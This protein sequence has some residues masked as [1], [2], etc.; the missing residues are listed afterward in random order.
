M[1]LFP[2]LRETNIGEFLKAHPETIKKA[3]KTSHFEYEPYLE[4]IEHDGSVQ[5]R[6]INPD[7]MVRRD[8]GFYDIYDLKTALL[9]KK[10]IVKGERKRRRFIDCVEEGV[11]QLSNYREY[12]QYPKNQE[13][14]KSKYG[15]EVNEPKLVLLVGS[16][17]NTDKRQIVEACRRY[18]NANIID[19]DTFAHLFYGTVAKT[20]NVET[21]RSN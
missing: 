8:D 2:G 21:R 19:F 12:F 6:A 10:N 9:T 18:K 5:D 11:A 20:A 3:F 15:I 16:W 1:Y 17:E 13:F 4:W 7:L 14:A